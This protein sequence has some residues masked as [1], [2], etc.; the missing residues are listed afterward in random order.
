MSS[1][2]DLV[3]ASA[4]LARIRAAED[5]H[6]SGLQSLQVT[7]AVALPYRDSGELQKKGS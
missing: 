3:W 5:H 6:M 2:V 7:I 1:S 4:P